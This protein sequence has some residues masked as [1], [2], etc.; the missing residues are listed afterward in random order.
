MKAQFTSVLSKFEGNLWGTHLEVPDAVVQTFLNSNI[1]RIK[2]SVNGSKPIHCALMSMG[3]GRWFI[4]VN[5]AFCKE[6]YLRVSDKLQVEIEEDSSKYGM[7]MPIELEEMLN[8]DLEANIYFEALTPGK[9]RNL[10][11]FVATIKTSE[12]R[13]RRALVVA[14]H[15]TSHRGQIDFKDLSRE[16]KEANNQNRY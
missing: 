1:K 15:L 3:N 8:Q 4:N 5:K 6:H 11:H 12:I 14:K 10:I 16:I 7:E 2:C 9:Q 13:I